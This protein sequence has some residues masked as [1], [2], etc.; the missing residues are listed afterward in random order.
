M[1]CFESC[2]IFFVVVAFFATWLI[3]ASFDFAFLVGSSIDNFVHSL[4]QQ[5]IAVDIDVL[6]TRNGTEEALYNGAITVSGD[7]KV[8]WTLMAVSHQKWTARCN[9]NNS[10][11]LTWYKRDTSWF[12][13]ENL[14]NTYLLAISNTA[15][16]GFNNNL[17]IISINFCL[18]EYFKLYSW[19]R[20][21]Q[22]LSLDLA[23]GLQSAASPYCSFIYITCLNL[24]GGFKTI[25]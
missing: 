11:E 8:C 5:S 2:F 10:N 14:S 16:K 19:W 25:Q 4:R 17:Q 20:W 7:E 13:Q 3:F 15:T 18:I 12:S 21:E 24:Q 23:L 1:T 9:L 22:L 6:G